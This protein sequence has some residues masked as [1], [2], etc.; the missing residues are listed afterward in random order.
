MGLPYDSGQCEEEAKGGL[1]RELLGS[2][3]QGSD[4]PDF[5]V[6]HALRQLKQECVGSSWVILQIEIP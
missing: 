1:T 2:G 3:P 4:L 6:R 5:E